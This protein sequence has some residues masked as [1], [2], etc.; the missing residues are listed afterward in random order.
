[1][2]L[3]DLDSGRVS[4]FPSV[5]RTTSGAEFPIVFRDRVVYTV[6]EFTARPPAPSVWSQALDATEP[7]LA[8]DRASILTLSAAPNRLWIQLVDGATDEGYRVAEIDLDGRRVT[9]LTVPA[10]LAVVGASMDGL[11]LFGSGVVF[12]M[13]R[14]GA[15]RPMATGTFIDS[16]ATGVLYDDCAVAGPCTLRYVNLQS[17]TSIVGPSATL[18]PAGGGEHVESVLSPDGRWL[19]LRDGLLDRR[20]N[21]R[22][23]HGYDVR[24]WQW[25]AD[26]EW[27]FLSSNLDAVAWNLRDMRRVELGVD[28]RLTG[29]ISP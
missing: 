5:A 20:S 22:H 1:M 18:H 29:V 3:V 2:T 23:D 19:L 21:T 15:I 16:N 17:S 14:A 8:A 25:S 27:L 6:Y 26:G 13:T 9:T 11:W 28:D 4:R 10:G 24:G 12:A 7:T